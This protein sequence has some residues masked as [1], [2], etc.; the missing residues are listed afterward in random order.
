MHGTIGPS[1][2]AAV[3][4]G[5]ELKVWTQNQ[6][7]YPLQAAVAEALRLQLDDV[8]VQFIPGAG[9][10]GHSGA[11]DAAFDAALIAKHLIN[12]S[13]LLKWTRED[14][15]CWEPYGSAMQCNLRRV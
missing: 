3:F 4:D 15:H 10:Y 9:V 11:D 7:V 2:G 8:L 6:G 14:E 5:Q 13:I 1:S 12:F